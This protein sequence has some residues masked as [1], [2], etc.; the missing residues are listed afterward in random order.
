MTHELGAPMPASDRLY[1][2]GKALARPVARGWLTLSQAD[3]FIEHDAICAWRDGAL[4]PYDPDH[5]AAGLRHILRL[6]LR[7]ERVRRALATHRIKQL[8]RPM[9]ALHKRWG[10]LMAESHGYNG[11]NGFPLT[12]NEVSDIVETEVWF[13]LPHKP[14]GMSRYAR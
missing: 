7:D 1:G 6:K 12:E 3:C 8:L 10:E 5:V 4:G 13:A 2:L 11:E 14:R 9:I